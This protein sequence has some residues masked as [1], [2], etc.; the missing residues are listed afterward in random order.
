MSIFSKFDD[1]R[2]AFS[3]LTE[4]ARNPFDIRFEKILSP[5]EAS[6]M[7]AASCCLEPT[8]TSA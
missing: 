3:A 7:A 6:S 8:I 4:I 5:T 1:V 2:A